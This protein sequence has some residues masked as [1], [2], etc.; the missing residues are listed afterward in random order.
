MGDKVDRQFG[1]D[2]IDH[3]TKIDLPENLERWTALNIREL[4]LDY[5]NQFNDVERGTLLACLDMF[6]ARKRS[7]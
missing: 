1:W 5:G 6:G 3:Q 4:L 2:A 7:D